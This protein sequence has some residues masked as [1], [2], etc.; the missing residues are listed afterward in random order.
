MKLCRL[1]VERRQRTGK[2][3]TN[4]LEVDFHIRD[5]DK[6]FKMR[7]A[8]DNRLENLLGDARDDTLEF[9][10]VNVGTL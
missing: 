2:K 4:L 7:V 9:L 5:F 3:V 6:I 10:V 8:F 1:V